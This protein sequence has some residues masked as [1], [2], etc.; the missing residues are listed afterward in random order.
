[1]ISIP[2]ELIHLCFNVM[3]RD[4]ENKRDCFFGFDE[5]LTATSHRGRIQ[6]TSATNE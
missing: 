3:E 6:L 2:I 1:L 4:S 5:W